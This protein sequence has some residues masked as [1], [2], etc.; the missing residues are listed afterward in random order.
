M[1][2]AIRVKDLGESVETARV[3]RLTCK[4]GDRVAAGVALA[5]L[6][7]DKANVTVN[8]PVACVITDVHVKV[9]DEVPKDALLIEIE[10]V[11]P[12]D[13]A[14]PQTAAEEE[15][16]PAPPA[17]RKDDDTRPKV[18]MALVVVGAIVLVVGGIP[19]CERYNAKHM[20][21]NPTH[22]WVHADA[23]GKPVLIVTS[24]VDVS[25]YTSATRIDALDPETGTRFKREP[26][27][28][29]D[30]QP[31][32]AGLMWCSTGNALILRDVRTLQVVAT[33]KDQIAKAVPMIGAKGIHAVSV[34]PDGGAGLVV[35]NDNTTWAIDPVSCRSGCTAQERI[36]VSTRGSFPGSRPDWTWTATTLPDG[37]EP[38]ID[39]RKLIESRF[40]G[41][42][43]GGPL[44]S[45]DGSTLYVMSK[46]SLD[47]AKANLLVSA[48]T[49]DGKLRWQTTAGAG[50]LVGAARAG[51]NILVASS[52]VYALAEDT[53]KI[54]WSHQP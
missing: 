40:I 49:V 2:I 29:P 15:S 50:R 41:D 38:Q 11:D 9:G 8:A 43:N 39:R 35:T 26:D 19:L 18:I 52:A 16:L 7:T 53:G 47:M 6:E 17:S 28:E 21:G 30:C 24:H 13:V 34:D 3:A 32:P 14:P 36:S 31:A 10:P 25:E 45:A 33:T 5:E 22:A 42:G 54:V 20:E 44:L 37:R 23:T 12:K 4:V 48:F 1:R 27:G 51:K 46:D